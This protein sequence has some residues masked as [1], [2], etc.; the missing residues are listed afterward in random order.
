[1]K[2]SQKLANVL[3]A[4]H[5]IHQYTHISKV[6]AQFAKLGQSFTSVDWDESLVLAE[7]FRCV[8]RHCYWNCLKISK[9]RPDLRYFEGFANHYMFPVEHSWLVRDDG[10]VIDPTWVSLEDGD[11]DEPDYF[12]ITIPVKDAVKFRQDNKWTPSW[13]LYLE[14]SL[15]GKNE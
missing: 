11:G 12:G 15:D 6:F 5:S 9:A 4:G 14:G 1:M 3:K 8:P 2:S 10:V 13:Y 7:T